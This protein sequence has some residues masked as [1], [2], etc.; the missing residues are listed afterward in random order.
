MLV[1]VAGVTF[2]L[3][4]AGRGVLVTD[5]SRIAA[6][7]AGAG[8]AVVATS[9]GWL[10]ARHSSSPRGSK[11]LVQAGGGTWAGR[12][13]TVSNTARKRIFA[14]V[15]LGVEGFGP[16]R[17]GQGARVSRRARR[18]WAFLWLG[19]QGWSPGRRPPV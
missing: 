1:T 8:A 10:V 19:R 15:L 4:S 2:A 5:Q 18:A 12:P 7:V 9:G 6:G 13:V 11:V 16:V 17:Q 3:A 14:F